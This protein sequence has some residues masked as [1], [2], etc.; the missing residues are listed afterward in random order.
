MTG[1]VARANR[2]NLRGVLKGHVEI[3]RHLLRGRF[4]GR[5]SAQP[6]LVHDL[7]V[8]FITVSSANGCSEAWIRDRTGHKTSAKRQRHRGAARKR[9]DLGLGPP[10]LFHHAIPE[11]EPDAPRVTRETK[12]GPL[13]EWHTQRT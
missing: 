9:A 1:T 7:Q 3:L 8:T 4:G 10:V 11:L 12:K 5:F 6:F 2:A 13:A